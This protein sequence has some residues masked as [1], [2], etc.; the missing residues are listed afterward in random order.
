MYPRGPLDKAAVRDL[1]EVFKAACT[2]DGADVIYDA[3]GGDY[4]EA[5]L[6]AIA[7]KGRHLVMGL[8]A[9]IPDL[10]LNLTLLKG[11][12]V[13]GVFLGEAARRFPAHHRAS[14]DALLALY[15]AD[16][17]R[18]TVTERFPL[19]LGAEAISR[20]GARQARGKIVVMV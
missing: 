12:Q 9:G 15:V 20:L 8:P 13:V 16:R 10:P 19:A 1:S 4:T 5:A 7:W 3:V 17:I 2:P 18:P 6:R 11:C 14:V